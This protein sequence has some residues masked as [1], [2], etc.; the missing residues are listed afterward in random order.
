MMMIKVA[1]ACTTEIDNIEVAVSEITAQLAAQGAMDVHRLGIISCHYEFVLTGVPEALCRALPFPVMGMS[2]AITGINPIAPEAAADTADNP[3]CLSLMVLSGGDDM[4][5]RFETVVTEPVKPGMNIDD[6]IRPVF[7]GKEK[8]KLALTFGTGI[9]V[10]PGDRLVAAVTEHSGGAPLFGAFS[11]DDS[12]TYAEDCFVV[13]SQGVFRDRVGFALLYGDIEPKFYSASISEKN[14]LPN[15]S[16]VTAV[17]GREIQSINNKPVTDFLDSYGIS[18]ETLASGG[19]MSLSLILRDEDDGPYYTRV[20][21]QL[22]PE[23]TLIC[24]GELKEGTHIRLGWMERND[25]LYT[26]GEV[27][28]TV[29]SEN[30]G[31]K[32]A[33]LI[34]SCAT[35][36]SELGADV[37]SEVQVVREA[38]GQ[39]PF[40]MA[41]AGGELGPIVYKDGRFS[42]KFFNQTFIVCV[43]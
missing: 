7:A 2:T 37:L 1:T 34:Y 14:I 39:A 18:G 42:N 8:P 31:Q 43:L 3:L 21:M 17:S 20:M 24:A 15:W 6:L 13:S 29:L 28:Q 30:R 4:D 5:F 23:N 38:M 40:M 36:S 9:S 33:A 19:G 16:V 26:A 12:P 32:A 11:V 35:R 10:L 41:Y 25:M 27:M 22:T